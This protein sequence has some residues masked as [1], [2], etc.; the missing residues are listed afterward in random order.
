M[1]DPS[2]RAIFSW[3]IGMPGRLPVDHKSGWRNGLF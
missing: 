2:A 1:T 3:S